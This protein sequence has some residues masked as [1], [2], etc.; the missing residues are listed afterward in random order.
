[1][2]LTKNVNG[3]DVQCSAEEEAAIRAE[4]AANEQK[5]IDD[6][7]TEKIKA[8]KLDKD[9]K[10]AIGKLKALGLTDDEISALKN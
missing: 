7:A 9:K 3:K 1:M 5:A 4:W 2:V 10:S 8:D 6:A